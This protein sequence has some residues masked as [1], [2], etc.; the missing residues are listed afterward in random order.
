MWACS[1]DQRAF[2]RGI[3]VVDRF[4]WV[5]GAVPPS[6][7][8]SG[9]LSAGEIENAATAALPTGSQVLVVAPFEGGDVPLDPR[10]EAA[11]HPT[12]WLVRAMIGSPNQDG[13]ATIEEVVID[14]STGAVIAQRSL[15][16]EPGYRP[17]LLAL[18]ETGP[19]N[20]GAK[21]EIDA[22]N[23]TPVRT[24]EILW[25]RPAVLDAGHYT[26]RAWLPSTPSTGCSLAVDL[27]PDGE[28]TYRVVFAKSGGCHW[29]PANITDYPGEPSATPSPIAPSTIAPSPTPTALL[30]G[31]I[32]EAEAIVLAGEYSGHATVVS[33]AAGLHRDLTTV[34]AQFDPR[35]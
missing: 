14:D 17:A 20:L 6:D 9:R 24:G 10:V 26:V 3:F 4:A 29:L 22:A 8:P 5:A 21:F 1:L 19:E 30:S 2:C 35:R 11:T 31:G 33:A 32:P 27:I 16:S 23:A 12:A 34:G 28:T 13:A 7:E 15:A 18:Q 25:D